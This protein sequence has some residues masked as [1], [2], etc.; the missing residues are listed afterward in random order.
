[1]AIDF[2]YN[3]IVF[4]FQFSIWTQTIL[5]RHFSHTFTAT[6]YFLMFWLLR[7]R[8]NRCWRW[9]FSWWWTGGKWRNNTFF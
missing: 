7:L 6:V 5:F 9:C 1:M 8:C 4:I 3:F 2:W